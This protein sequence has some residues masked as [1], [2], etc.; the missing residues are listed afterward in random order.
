[1]LVGVFF[2]NTVYSEKMEEKHTNYEW[3][4]RFCN[5]W[6][7]F[8]YQSNN[9]GDNEN[10]KEILKKFNLR[11]MLGLCELLNV[12]PQNTNVLCYKMFCSV[13]QN[14]AQRQILTRLNQSIQA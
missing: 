7:K 3:F 11:L 8:Y 1:M 14:I 12:A 2:L 13:H 4:D 6:E 5:N 10:N 9:T